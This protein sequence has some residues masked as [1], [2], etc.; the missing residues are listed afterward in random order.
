MGEQGHWG[1]TSRPHESTGGKGRIV[2]PRLGIWKAP[3]WNASL[4]PPK[5]G[6]FGNA[7][8]VR[9]GGLKIPG[10]S[11]ALLPQK[12]LDPRRP[13]DRISSVVTLNIWG[14]IAFHPRTIL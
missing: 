9:L 14:A 8:L 10:I 12:P 4:T 11:S 5:K 1:E 2:F 3:S 6:T 13:A 7:F